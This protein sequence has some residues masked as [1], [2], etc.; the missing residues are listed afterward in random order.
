MAMGCA[1]CACCFFFSG[2]A[3]ELLLSPRLSSH[4]CM[5]FFGMVVFVAVVVLLLTPAPIL[6]IF[7]ATNATH[8]TW[9]G[10]GMEGFV[11]L[12][13]YCSV[14]GVQGFWSEVPIHFKLTV[15][16]CTGAG[17][18]P[19]SNPNPTCWPIATVSFCTQC[20]IRTPSH[21]SPKGVRI[22]PWDNSFLCCIPSS[23]RTPRP[24]SERQSSSPRPK[25]CAMFRN[26]TLQEPVPGRTEQP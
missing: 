9:L 10:A 4:H 8:A 25:L 18:R 24:F 5:V 12:S 19:N 22:Y 17:A 15:G 26:V 14:F 7:F 6:L 21:S 20:P 2:G 16:F 11:T 23:I 1:C 3:V 13:G